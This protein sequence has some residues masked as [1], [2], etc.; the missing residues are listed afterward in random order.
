MKLRVECV[1]DSAT[2]L[3]NTVEITTDRFD[4]V[5]VPNDD[6]L[7]ARVALVTRIERPERFESRIDPDPE[8]GTAG[9]VTF[10]VDGALTDS[11]REEFYAL[12]SHL[13]FRY[14]VFRV[15]WDSPKY[16]LI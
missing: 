5:F 9:R 6:G 15:R 4:Y 14:P 16:E 8:H 11:I 1:V 10:R 13:A 7:L 12:E 3:S 2:V